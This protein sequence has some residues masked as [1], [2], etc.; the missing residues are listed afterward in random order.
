MSDGNDHRWAYYHSMEHDCIILCNLCQCVNSTIS[1]LWPRFFIPFFRRFS[2][3]PSL[4]DKHPGY[5]KCAPLFLGSAS[6]YFVLQCGIA[7][8][9]DQSIQSLTLLAV[10]AIPVIMALVIRQ[11]TDRVDGTD[12]MSG[13]LINRPVDCRNTGH[14]AAVVA[15]CFDGTLGGITGGHGSHQNQHMLAGDHGLDVV[16]ENDLGVGIVLRLQNVNSLVLVDG[17]ETGLGQFLSNAGT[18]NSG[19]VQ[20]QDGIHWCIIDKMRHQFV[21]GGPGLAQTGL[22]ISNVNIVVNMG[23]IGSKVAFRKTQGDVAAGNGQ[24][25]VAPSPVKGIFPSVV[26]ISVALSTGSHRPD[27]L[28]QPVLECTDFPHISA[29]LSDYFICNNFSTKSQIILYMYLSIL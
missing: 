8:A 20:T 6:C 28:R 23:M 22:L 12:R 16:T 10:G 24:V 25:T 3:A 11:V 7:E 14:I 19:T 9:I 21:S 5:R 27:F 2:P 1:G 26:Y 18:Q 17:A 15:D 13:D 29:R 4:P